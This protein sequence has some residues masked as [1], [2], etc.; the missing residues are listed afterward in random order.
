MVIVAVSEDVLVLLIKE[1]SVI[2][3]LKKEKNIATVTFVDAEKHDEDVLI[4]IMVAV[5]MDLIAAKRFSM[6]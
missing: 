6:A 4:A 5:S 2:Y 1:I 3:Y